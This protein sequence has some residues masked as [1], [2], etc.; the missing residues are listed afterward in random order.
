MKKNDLL[1]FPLLFEAIGKFLHDADVPKSQQGI[2]R[3]S[4]RAFDTIAKT[5]YSRQAKVY[6]CTT[7]SRIPHMPLEKGYP[8]TTVS[9]ISPMPLSRAAK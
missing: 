8:C 2:L 3:D 7:V 4:R 5:L 6:P 1:D 9:R